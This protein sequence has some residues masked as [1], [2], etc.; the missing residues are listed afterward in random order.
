[1]W[2]VLTVKAFFP[3]VPADRTVGLQPIS[4]AGH[5]A[6]IFLAAVWACTVGSGAKCCPPPS[7]QCVCTPPV[8]RH[9]GVLRDY[10]QYWE[11]CH[12]CCSGW[13]FP[14][15][16][17]TLIVA[18][19]LLWD[20]CGTHPAASSLLSHIGLWEHPEPGATGGERGEAERCVH[21]VFPG[22]LLHQEA[23][24]RAGGESP[25][26]RNCFT[27]PVLL[28]RRDSLQ[29]AGLCSHSPNFPARLK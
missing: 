22:G 10:G 16:G 21:G 14:E 23:G 13:D 29:G 18:Q 5:M 3:I 28:V 11:N 27:V 24:S 8:P 25:W 17:K 9:C 15:K 7:L 4:Q 1:M 20:P 2:P 19:Q 6:L 12:C 26:N